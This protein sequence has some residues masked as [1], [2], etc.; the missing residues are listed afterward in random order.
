[1][2]RSALRDLAARH[3]FRPSKALGQHFLVDPNLARAIVVDAGV[4]P[5]GRVLEVG[6]GLGS[7][8]TALAQAGCEVLALEIDRALAAALEEVTAP[9]GDRV[10][11]VI[12]DAMRADWDALLPGLGWGMVSNLPYN[13]SVPLL[14]DLLASVPTIDRYLVMVQREVGQRLVA[15]PGE[16]AYGAVSV[17]VAYRA[18]AHAVRR[19][20]ADVFWPR[21]KVDSVLVRL[22]P[23]AP[24]V[25]VD[26]VALFAVI[27]GGFAERRKTMGNALRR[28][29]LD[30]AS[31]ARTMEACGLDP[32]VRAERLGLP[33]FARIA[34]ALLDEGW[35]P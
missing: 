31:S 23:H 18:D 27:D 35:S 26:P 12:E 29:G 13:V 11:V 15:A 22:D 14:L 20:P 28:L 1:M 9:Y 32:R 2:G 16:E 34:E 3:G 33:E 24:P 25:D 21:P 5:G 30:A 4:G 8:T 7:L 19:V 6:A 17:R 10:R